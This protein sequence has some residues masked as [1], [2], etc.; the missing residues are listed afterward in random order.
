MYKDWNLSYRLSISLFS[1][2]SLSGR[3]AFTKPG[4][5]PGTCG[6]DMQRL[7]LIWLQVFFDDHFWCPLMCLRSQHSALTLANSW[8]WGKHGKWILPSA[9]PWSDVIKSC[10]PRFFL[11]V[12]KNWHEGGMWIIEVQIEAWCTN[13]RVATH[14]CLQ[15]LKYFKGRS[16]SGHP[17]LVF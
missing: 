1:W 13:S 11:Y 3:S 5:S 12:L 16:E 14:F 7:P 2:F 15:R 8:S 10:K 17:S 4:T 6:K 9:L